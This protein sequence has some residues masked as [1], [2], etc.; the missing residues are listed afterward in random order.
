MSFEFMIRN[1]PVKIVNGY[2]PLITDSPEY[3]QVTGTGMAT[4]ADAMGRADLLDYDHNVSEQI[5]RIWPPRVKKWLFSSRLG[6]DV[7]DP[8]L[9]YLDEPAG[10]PPATDQVIDLVRRTKA[11]VDHCLAKGSPLSGKIPAE[12]FRS[13]DGWIVTAEEC[14]VIA[15]A[16]RHYLA[17]VGAVTNADLPLSSS[18]FFFRQDLGQTFRTS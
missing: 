18:R 6:E 7:L 14:A 12:K 10:D 2:D 13:N 3:F 1:R 8:I 11:E 5:R 9:E 16:L 15:N 4:I 17:N